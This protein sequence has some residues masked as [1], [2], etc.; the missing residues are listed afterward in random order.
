MSD[1]FTLY[2]LNIF[3]IHFVL[4]TTS[5]EWILSNFASAPSVWP[6]TP[7][8]GA[9]SE[10]TCNL[11][12]QN[13]RHFNFLRGGWEEN[14]PWNAWGCIFKDGGR[15]SPIKEKELSS[16]LSTKSKEEQQ[17]PTSVVPIILEVHKHGVHICLLFHVLQRCSQ[18][19]SHRKT[20]KMFGQLRI[21]KDTYLEQKK[22]YWLFSALHPPK[23]GNGIC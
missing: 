17:I 7:P 1:P 23:P 22:S 15:G 19:S 20:V 13:A 3:E 16:C 4:L 11:M 12:E 18:T 10:S 5:F 14:N 6:L 2:V 9:S 21:Q 8:A